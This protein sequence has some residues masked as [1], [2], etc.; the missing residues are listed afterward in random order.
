VKTTTIAIDLAKSV[1]EI[2]ISNRPG[3]VER[4]HR[5]SRKELAHFMAAQPPAAVLMEACGSSHYWGR[6]FQGFGHEV[7]LLP[8]HAVRPYVQ[9]SKTDRADVK[10]M[11]EASRNTDIRPV[12]VKSE[13]QQQ[14]T[15]LHRVRSAWLRTRTMRTNCARAL[16]SELGMIFAQGRGFLGSLKSVIED[17][18]VSVPSALRDTLHELVLEIEELDR[19]IDEVSQ[20]MENLAAQ[21]PVVARLQT[22]PGIGPITSTALVGFVGDAARF[23]S[24]RQFACYLGLT[25][26]EH[27]SGPRRILGRISKRGDPY[28]R[29]LLI[30]GAQTILIWAAHKP[31]PDPFRQWALDLV[32]RR[33]RKKAVV[34]VANKMARMVWAVWTKGESFQPGPRRQ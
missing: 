20:R 27:S 30:Q 23:G 16:L 34:A 26:R 21:T 9:R 28:L 8:P 25:P 12:P 17:A 2:G 11:L 10:G 5:V 32:Q 6:T 29:R 14:L 4:T 15:G 31:N 24:G 3:H 22:I 18:D 33:G 7:K 13:S 19:R 1:F